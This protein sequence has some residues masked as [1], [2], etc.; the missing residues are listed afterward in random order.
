M[1]TKGRKMPYSLE[2]C[3]NTNWY[4]GNIILGHCT[5]VLWN[6]LV[7]INIQGGDVYEIKSCFIRKWLEW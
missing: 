2:I 3:W 1:S 6:V 7:L 5:L 4:D